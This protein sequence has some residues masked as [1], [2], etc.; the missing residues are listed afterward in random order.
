VTPATDLGQIRAEED[1][2][3]TTYGWID[4]Q[5]G[6]VRIPVERAMELLV[7]RGLPARAQGAEAADG[8]TK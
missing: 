8:G 3:L 1:A 5:G 6:I 2:V 4:E 7:E